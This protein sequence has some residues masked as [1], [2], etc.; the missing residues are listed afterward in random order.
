MMQGPLGAI[1]GSSNDTMISLQA[2]QELLNATA[3]MSKADRI[4]ALDLQDPDSLASRLNQ[5]IITQTDAHASSLDMRVTVDPETDPIAAKARKIADETDS[6]ED[7]AKQIE[8][9][10]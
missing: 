7:F 8:N 9:E 1:L 4:K 5:R 2:E 10:L 3:D 6:F